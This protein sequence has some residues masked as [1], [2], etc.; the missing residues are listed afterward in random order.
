MSASEIVINISLI[1]NF[2]LILLL[3]IAV[4]PKVIQYFNKKKKQRERLKTYKIQ[5]IVREY[6]K[7]LQK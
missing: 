3:L 6:L 1:V 2:T 5:K 4:R 7:E